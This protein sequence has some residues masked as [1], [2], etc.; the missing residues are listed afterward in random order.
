[1][2][3][4]WIILYACSVAGSNLCFRKTVG[5]TTGNMPWWIWF[6]VGNVAGFFA[7]LSITMALK[8]GNAPWVFGIAMGF[9]FIL[10][11]G[12]LIVCFGDRLTFLQ[13]TGMLLI[14]IG[15]AL[16]YWKP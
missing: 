7:P 14:G 4:F 9:G 3:V 13:S 1:M 8:E 6:G 2:R 15:I 16:L 5:L 11:Q 12:L 10:L